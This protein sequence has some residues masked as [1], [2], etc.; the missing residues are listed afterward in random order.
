M[1]KA[2][3]NCILNSEKCTKDKIKKR[4]TNTSLFSYSMII[5]V[6]TPYNNRKLKSL[7]Q[8]FISNKLFLQAAT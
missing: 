1:R 7:T 8:L 6:G 5:A 2:K 4:R 3:V